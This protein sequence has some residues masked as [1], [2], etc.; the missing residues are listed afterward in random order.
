MEQTEAR[1]DRGSHT[2]FPRQSS[3]L[4]RHSPER[5]ESEPENPG[6]KSDHNELDDRLVLESARRRAKLAVGTYTR[7]FAGPQ[8]FVDTT[9]RT[10]SDIQHRLGM[11]GGSSWLP[12][13]GQMD[14]R[15]N[16]G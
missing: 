12:E 15:S 10:A 13:T 9:Q 16:S 7:R 4:G 5:L 11:S 14:V 2:N 3:Q 6:D 1:P 8:G